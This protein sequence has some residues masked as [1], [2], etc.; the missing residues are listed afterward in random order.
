M[1]ADQ[2]ACANRVLRVVA[3]L[4]AF[5][6]VVWPPSKVDA[7]GKDKDKRE[8]SG[9]GA[10]DF[11][12]SD[13]LYASTPNVSYGRSLAMPDT[14]LSRKVLHAASEDGK[15]WMILRFNRRLDNTA[16]K[17]KVGLTGTGQWELSPGRPVEYEFDRGKITIKTNRRGKSQVAGSAKGLVNRPFIAPNRPSSMTFRGKVR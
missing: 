16:K 13:V 1:R 11:E 3:V 4:L 12:L 8:V 5:A 10:S 14:R 15:D 7:K 2:S 9:R 6:I 17:N